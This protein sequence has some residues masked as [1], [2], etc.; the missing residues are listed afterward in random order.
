MNKTLIRNTII[1]IRKKLLFVETH[2]LLL[3][4]TKQKMTASIGLFECKSKRRAK[5]IKAVQYHGLFYHE[6]F[7]HSSFHTEEGQRVKKLKGT[8][9]EF[10][11]Y[12]NIER[13]K[14]L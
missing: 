9:V 3:F 13:D 8:V 6:M 2:I 5:E 14:I 12:L 7:P 10:V 4:S 1:R 11:K